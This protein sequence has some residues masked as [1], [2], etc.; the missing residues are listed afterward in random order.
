MMAALR[1]PFGDAGPYLVTPVF[2]ALL[3]WLTFVYVRQRAAPAPALAAALL[4]AA[5]PPFL[6]QTM[7]SMSDVPVAALWLAVLVRLPSPTTAH[8]LVTGVLMALALVVRPNLFLVAGGVWL[9]AA[10]RAAGAADR[11]A[12]IAR[13][14]ALAGPVAVAAAPIAALNTIWRGSPLASGYGGLSDI[15]VLEV[16]PRNARQ[17][18][19]WLWETDSWIVIVGLVA[20]PWLA[21]RG[22]S[23]PAW[24]LG[25]AVTV[26]TWVSYV[27][28]GTFTEWWYL[29]FQMPGWP[30]LTGAGCV[31]I[32]SLLAR[33]SRPV[34]TIAIVLLALA[35][36]LHGMRLASTDRVFRLWWGEQR[37]VAAG[38]WLKARTP[39]NAVCITLQHSGTVGYYGDRASV[40]YDYLAPDAL[41]PL[42]RRLAAQGRPVYF[43]GEDWEEIE[44]R[45]RFGALS[46]L[47]RLDWPPLAEIDAGLKVRMYALSPDGPP[48]TAAATEVVPFDHD[49]PWERLNAPVGSWIA[50]A[51]PLRERLVAAAPR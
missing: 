46:P 25:A 41:E 16:M 36:G 51:R 34:A 47:G 7:W 13:L 44:F 27:G 9:V 24:R 49:R 20:L 50:P 2:A 17:Q 38:E 3:V 1:V 31:V 26:L 12:A 21:L 39:A 8:A 4:V 35:G 33:R 29:R 5:S 28:W 11:R 32:W 22:R 10:A 19:V 15:F 42:V 18:L 30:V 43:V 45:D 40:R 48:R 23:A 6:F 37:Y 14:A